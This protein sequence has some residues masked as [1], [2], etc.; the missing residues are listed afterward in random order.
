MATAQTID[1]TQTRSSQLDLLR[2]IAIALVFT[3]HFNM[4][5]G[6]AWFKPVGKVGEIGI[7]LFFVLS[8][9]LIASQLLKTLSNHGTVS[10]RDFYIRRSLRI[11][12]AYFFVLGLYLTIPAF[13]ER[14]A[15][16]PLWKLI[17]FTQNFGLD[18]Y[19]QA[20]FS[21]AWSLCVEEQFYLILPPLLLF[22]NRFGTFR[23]S[24]ILLM[25]VIFGGI[26][27]R[28]VLWHHFVEPFYLTNSKE[29]G[30]IQF[31]REIYYPTYCRLDGLA[32]GVSL[33]ALYRLR[34]H[35]WKKM[36]AYSN[37]F[38]FAGLLLLI[39]SYFLVTNRYTQLSASIAY[40]LLSTGFGGIVVAALSP[41]GLFS[42]IRIP[43]VRIGATLAFAFYLSHKQMIQ[44][45]QGWLTDL[46]V[47]Q[48][49][50]LYP[51]GIILVCLVVASAIYFLVERPFL[52]LRDRWLH[53]PSL[54]FK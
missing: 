22:M 33:A 6:N 42:K 15:L 2:T 40:P 37:H 50:I 32:I 9:F 45:S 47:T 49:S 21:H 17:T 8:G 4:F 3:G 16:P 52:Y 46:G 7:D 53:E 23:K 27:L 18:L 38:L 28:N 20:G 11:W 19:T 39:A 1:L 34:P 54:H 29:A 25:I 30:D 24:L 26:I 41:Q 44:L 35:I 36:C 5:A 31:Y 43:G 10:L 13:T 48:D 12:P 51:S 14:S